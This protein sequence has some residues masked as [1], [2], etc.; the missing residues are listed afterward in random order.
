MQYCNHYLTQF[1]SPAQ[2]IQNQ[3]PIHRPNHKLKLAVIVHEY[4]LYP[5]LQKTNISLTIHGIF[6]NLNI[7]TTQLD[8]IRV[9]SIHRKEVH[10][11]TS[12]SLAVSLAGFFPRQQK[13]SL[14]NEGLV[15]RMASTAVGNEGLVLQYG[16][17]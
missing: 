9:L 5:L 3:A 17:C 15:A 1:H 12:F 8:V 10:F 14:R 6:S 13:K 16:M 7:K 4:I 2:F 11:E